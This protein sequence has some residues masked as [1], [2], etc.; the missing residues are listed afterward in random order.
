MTTL[1][2]KS[3]TR[4]AYETNAL[5]TKMVRSRQMRL[6]GK[7]QTPAYAK[8]TVPQDPRGHECSCLGC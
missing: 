4:L 2:A 3:A 7:T 1:A 6:D 8:C 5:M